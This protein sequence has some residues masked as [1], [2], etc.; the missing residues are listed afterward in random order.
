MMKIVIFVE[1]GNVQFVYSTDETV[2]VKLVDFD[3]LRAEK[4]NREERIR[5]LEEET[6]DLHVVL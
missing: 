4:K 2:D 6:R 1:G 5:I 3:N